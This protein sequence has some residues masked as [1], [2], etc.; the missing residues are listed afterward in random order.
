MKTPA[1]QFT[2]VRFWATQLSLR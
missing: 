2:N 1:T